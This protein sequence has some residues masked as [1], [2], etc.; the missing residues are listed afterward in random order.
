MDVLSNEIINHARDADCHKHGQY[1]E[2]GTQ[3]LA[4]SERIM[5]RGCHWCR[6][7][8]EANRQQAQAE[9]AYQQRIS[10]ANIP[11]RYKSST[12]GNYDCSS[13]N[14]KGFDIL[15][16]YAK[17]CGDALK[18]GKCLI[19]TG[20][21]GTGKT[22]LSVGLVKAFALSGHGVRYISVPNLI[23]EYRACYSRDS[24]ESEIDVINRYGGCAFLVLDE[25]GMQRGTED[26]QRIIH[27]VIDMRYNSVLPTVIVSNLS[28]E[29]IREMIGDRALDRLREGGGIA[30]SFVGESH[31]KAANHD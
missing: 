25:V 21:V 29:G 4:I 17:N 11:H 26:E 24:G 6:E 15:T 16:D 28:V 27:E 9:A 18:A 14:R 30:L 12:L 8:A 5:W 31:R 10:Y 20:T 13:V 3:Y 19:I 2:K 22:H 23:H 1:I 7:E